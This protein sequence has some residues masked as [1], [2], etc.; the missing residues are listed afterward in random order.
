MIEVPQG[1]G[2]HTGYILFEL[3]GIRHD[4]FTLSKLHMIIV[5]N[6]TVVIKRFLYLLKNGSSNAT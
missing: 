2:R 5:L 1:I 3:F 6:A 4:S